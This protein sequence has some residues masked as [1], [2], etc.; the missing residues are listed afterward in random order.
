MSLEKEEIKTKLTQRRHKNSKKWFDKDCIRLKSLAR[1]AANLK[2]KHPWNNN[3]QDYHRNILKEFKYT[4][5]AKKNQF[6]QNEI[7]KLNK[8]EGDNDFWNKWKHMG[9]DIT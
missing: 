5:R 7:T 4:C 1:K 8:I 2:H 9:E 3:L 6:W